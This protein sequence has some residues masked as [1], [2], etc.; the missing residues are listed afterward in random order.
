MRHGQ[1]TIAVSL[2]LFCWGGARVSLFVFMLLL[3][4]DTKE[5]LTPSPTSSMMSFAGGVE[6][7]DLG[8]HFDRAGHFDWFGRTLHFDRLD[9]F[10]TS[11][12]Q[13]FR[14][15]GHFD[16]VDITL[17]F[18]R[19]LHFDRPDTSIWADIT[20]WSGQTTFIE[21][22]TL[23]DRPDYCLQ[24]CMPRVCTLTL[25]LTL[26]QPSPCPRWL[27]HGSSCLGFALGK[28]S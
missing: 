20:F 14:S 21:P 12:G 28:I 13:T 19:T 1:A 8:G 10:Y 18:G 17:R 11:I 5:V 23:I 15:A 24:M 22:D 16:W 7:F 27:W 2:F 6:H 25:T 4:L 9:H 3:W 26:T